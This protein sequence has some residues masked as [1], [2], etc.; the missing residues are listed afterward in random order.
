MTVAVPRSGTPCRVWTIYQAR[1]LLCGWYEEVT[2]DPAAAAYS[3]KLHRAGEE[4]KENLR[5]RRKTAA[6]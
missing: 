5:E 1:C 3:A 6:T 4:H 2:G